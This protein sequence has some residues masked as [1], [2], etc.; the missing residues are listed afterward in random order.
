MCGITVAT[1]AELGKYGDICKQSFS[2]ILLQCSTVW[3]IFFF[4]ACNHPVVVITGTPTDRMGLQRSS[5][6][7]SL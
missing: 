5:L 3:E 6:K 7:I 4:C 1:R 2:E